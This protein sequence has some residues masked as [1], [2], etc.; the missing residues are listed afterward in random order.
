MTSSSGMKK[1]GMRDW[2]CLALGALLVAAA[3]P[4]LAQELPSA[5]LQTHLGV[6]TCASSVCH[7]KAVQS[8]SADVWLTEYTIWSRHDAHSDA[9]NVLRNGESKAIARKLGLDSATTAKV[10]LDCHADN[11]PVEMRGPKFQISDGVGCEACH[12]GSQPWIDSH[13]A[14]SVSRQANLDAGMYPT[15]KPEALAKLCVSCH[16]GTPEK[17]ASHDIMAAGHPRL[18]FELQAFSVN[19]P[20]HYHMD[21]DYRARKGEIG[22]VTMWVTGLLSKARQSLELI[23]SDRFA[24][25]GLFP[26]LAF[27]ECHACHHPMNDTRWSPTETSANLPI[28]VVRLDLSSERILIAITSVLAPEQSR[29]LTQRVAALNRASTQSTA[30]T[31]DKAMQLAACLGQL[32]ARLDG[33]SYTTAEVRAI[34]LAL[35]DN[36]RRGEYRDFTSAEQAWLGVE[37]LSIHLGKEKPDMLDKW[38]Q[39]VQHESGFSPARFALVAGKVWRELK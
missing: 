19:Q 5:A 1:G 34:R 15:D 18:A 21:D 11:V 37:T 39:T 16:V 36:A 9:W 12:G 30:Q 10:C 3:Y 4:A 14:R 20:R 8:K 13:T 25:H 23:Q 26:E 7:G 24:G 29:E 2:R 33:H 31:M 22:P 17:F 38:Y 6:A 27:F 35:L 28:G 32:M